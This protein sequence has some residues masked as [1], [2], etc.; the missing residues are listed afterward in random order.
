MNKQLLLVVVLIV[1]IS[2]WLG[3]QELSSSVLG[4]GATQSQSSKMIIRGTL[5]QN[6]I[7]P[8]RNQTDVLEAG[9]WHSRTSAT[10]SAP[11]I[12][13]TNDKQLQTS[14]QPVVNLATISYHAKTR[15]HV[16]MELYTILGEKLFTVFEG[17]VD[18]DFS[19]T[20]NTTSLA[21]GS[22]TLRCTS[23]QQSLTHVIVVQH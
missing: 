22:Y 12:S 6:V 10:A 7:G 14:P 5:G 1:T 16:T 3:A 23:A 18:G 15:E 2:S 19:T 4:S 9:F 11:D 13:T 21:S 20:L 8:T 17:T